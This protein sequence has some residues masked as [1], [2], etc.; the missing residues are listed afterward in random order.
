MN[1]YLAFFFLACG[2]LVL[3]KPLY[4]YLFSNIVGSKVKISGYLALFFGIIL[5]LTAKCF[6]LP[7]REFIKS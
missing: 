7:V 1:Y 4:T 6:L 3:V 5:F 2:L